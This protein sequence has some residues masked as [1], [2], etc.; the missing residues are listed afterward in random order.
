MRSSIALASAL[1]AS[2]SAFAPAPACAPAASRAARRSAVRCV[3]DDA[4][5]DG[6]TSRRAA[7]LG[8]VGVGLG[9]C[10]NVANAGYVTSL[11][12]E[13]TK[14]SDSDADDELLGS[15]KVQGAI[16]ALRGFQA[17]ANVLKGSFASEPNMQLIPVVRKEFD[18]AAVRDS[19]NV[20][21]TP[22]D[23]AT[24]ATLDRASRAILYDLT[25]LESAAR[26]KKGDPERTPKKIAAVNKW[27]SKLDADFT[28]YLA[29]F[30]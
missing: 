5:L 22:F 26:F 21:T 28:S 27:F 13:T 3:D 2:A 9:S 19:L 30:K 24:Q 10:A 4:L 6:A 14:P 16:K 25:E 23:D 18:F 20:A 17:S 11:G 7:L 29:Y 15:G 12:I 1:V 8:L